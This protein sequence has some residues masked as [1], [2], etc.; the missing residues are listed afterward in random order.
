MTRILNCKL[1]IWLFFII[2]F[3]HCEKE[4]YKDPLQKIILSGPEFVQEMIDSSE[5]EIQ[6]IYTQVERDKENIP[7]LSSFYINRDDSK[8]FYPASTVKMPI[9][10][11]A[12]QRI[13]E[14]K[15][16]NNR[17][18]VLSRLEID[19][20][21]SPQSSVKLDSS[22]LTGYPNVEHYIEK[23]FSVSDNNAYN[24]LY[25]FLGQDYINQELRTKGI[26]KNSRIR[27]RVG[28]SGFNTELNKYTNPIKLLDDE[29]T[30]L[31]DQDEYYALYSNFE[32]LR[33]TLKG[34]GYY[35][36]K[37]DTIISKPF[38]MSEKNYINLTD[39]ESSLSRIIFPETYEPNQRFNLTE[40]Q[41]DFLYRIM[42]MTPL[43]FEF[44]KGKKE[45]YDSYVKF[46]YNGDNQ[47][48]IPQN[49]NIY[50]KVGWAYGTLTDCSYIID[51][52]NNIEFF[53]TAT[54]HV[55][56]NGIFNDGIYEYKD[57]G[58]PFLAALGMSTYNY[59]R[60]R[61]RN[62]Q[63]DLFKFKY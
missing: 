28:V 13:N 9:A 2:L 42:P 24:R 58:L 37:L 40:E 50:N 61:K 35:D 8:Y 18:S 55:N 52:K 5:Y 47:Q 36:D 12:L 53:L 20:V 1:S 22:S 43:D 54:I 45:Y 10:F 60:K 4:A 41:Y 44:N 3:A 11:L 26:F 59:E 31:Y 63:P 19:S 29:G 14:L 30:L 27:T 46:F 23:I 16:E 56:K 7:H 38:D 62:Y 49:I 51:T 34:I 15:F 6:I 33:E 32:D 39:L 21:R 25:E 48:P 57:K 17:I